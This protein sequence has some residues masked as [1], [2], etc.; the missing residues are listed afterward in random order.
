[1]VVTLC[2]PTACC[3]ASASTS[4]ATPILGRCRILTGGL[5]AISRGGH[6]GAQPRRTGRT[7]VFLALCN[8]AV[9]FTVRPYRRPERA[10]TATRLLIWTASGHHP[11]RLPG[12]DFHHLAGGGQ[13]VAVSG[14]LCPARHLC[15]GDAVA[16]AAF[17]HGFGGY[18]MLAALVL[19]EWFGWLP[20]TVLWVR[21]SADPEDDFR[22]GV[23]A[24]LPLR[25]AH[26]RNHLPGHRQSPRACV[27]A[28]AVCAKRS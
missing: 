16:R 6:R 22:G 15:L 5:F 2:F 19:G 4:F 8:L 11:A 25:L 24:A 13:S 18:L 3:W 7:A 17:A 21:C 28:S 1:M 26:R 12:V 14:F 23:D 10:A 20:G 27:R 9:Y